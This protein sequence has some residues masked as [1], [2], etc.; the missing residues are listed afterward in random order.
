MGW[1]GAWIGAGHVTTFMTAHIPANCPTRTS[2]LQD[3]HRTI[4][5]PCCVPPN[6]RCSQHRPPP[7]LCNGDVFI[8]GAWRRV[9]HE[10]VTVTPVHILKELL[11]ESCR[12]WRGVARW[13]TVGCRVVQL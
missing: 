6:H 8:T 7:H 5:A 13:V 3:P 1:L 4:L 9:D 2:S 10:I 11:D 12:T